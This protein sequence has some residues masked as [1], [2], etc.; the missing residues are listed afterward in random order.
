MEINTLQ[1]R[2]NENAEAKFNALMNDLLKMAKLFPILYDLKIKTIEGREVPLVSEFNVGLFGKDRLS[3]FMETPF[4][5]DK[6]NY[7]S[8]K[9]KMIAEFAQQETD[10]LFRKF[11]DISTYLESQD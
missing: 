11:E 1:Q 6:T 5:V 10:E 3:K 2:I 9:A 8:V 7:L 4:L